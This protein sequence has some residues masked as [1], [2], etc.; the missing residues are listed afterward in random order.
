MSYFSE[1]H[2]HMPSCPPLTQLHAGQFTSH[3]KM[4]V[5]SWLQK[6]LGNVERTVTGFLWAGSSVQGAFNLQGWLWFLWLHPLGWLHGLRVDL[7]P[8]CASIPFLSKC[9]GV[10]NLWQHLLQERG[11]EINAFHWRR[12]EIGCLW[13]ATLCP[14]FLSMLNKWLLD[15]MRLETTKILMVNSKSNII[16]ALY[17]E[18]LCKASESLMGCMKDYEGGWVWNRKYNC[19]FTVNRINFPFWQGQWQKV[20]AVNSPGICSMR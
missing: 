14:V 13:N 19:S 7:R 18:I 12:L 10:K 20:C 15:T 9:L 3:A 1:S 17:S 6:I 2:T 8:I 11:K 16:P 4:G 5:T